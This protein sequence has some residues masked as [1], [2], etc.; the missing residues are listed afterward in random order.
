MSMKMADVMTACPYNI[1]A[2]SSIEQSLRTM[3][4]RE[5]RHLPVVERGALLGILS[6]RDIRLS[7]VVC[8][9]TG[10][11]PT[12]S[13]LCFK[14]P[15]VVRDDDEVAEIALEM[16]QKKIDCAL[17]ADKDGNFVGIFT[18][19]DACRLLHLVLEEEKLKG[20]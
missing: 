15:Y 1:D 8:G 4:T 11:C 6:E 5:I 20:A 16:S 17:V 7:M 12:A 13:D 3:Q 9:A 10:F 18:T 19:T 14:E 2:S